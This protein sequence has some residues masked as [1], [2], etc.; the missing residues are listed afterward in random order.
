V[1]A[2]GSISFMSPRPRSLE[3]ITA[4]SKR[5][6]SSLAF[7]TVRIIPRSFPGACRLQRLIPRADW[8]VG[9]F[10]CAMPRG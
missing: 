5:M 8:Q 3:R 7:A 1:S 9:L 10:P 4:A 6:E 2:W